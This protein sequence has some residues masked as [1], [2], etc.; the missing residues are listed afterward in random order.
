MENGKNNYLNQKK[1]IAVYDKIEIAKKEAEKYIKETK[2]SVLLF[3][4]VNAGG[5]GDNEIRNVAS[6]FGI[7]NAENE[8][9]DVLK[10][11]LRKKVEKTEHG[12][13]KL[14]EFTRLD[15]KTEIKIVVQRGIDNKIIGIDKSKDKCWRFCDKD[16][17]ARGEKICSI[18]AGQKPV[19]VLQNYLLGDSNVLDGIKAKLKEIK[20]E[21]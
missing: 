19:I 21:E 17:M 3:N 15:E 11:Q 1:L 2:L 9:L 16:G 7:T 8:D 14:E 20:L 6:A 4:D 13:E 18:F 12:M 5:L 10:V